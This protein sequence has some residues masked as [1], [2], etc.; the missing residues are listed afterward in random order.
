MVLVALTLVV[1]CPLP[2]QLS[3]EG[4]TTSSTVLTQQLLW[5]PRKHPA[6]LHMRS[7]DYGLCSP[8][9]LVQ[10]PPSHCWHTT[11]PAALSRSLCS[12][13]RFQSPC[14]CSF[15]PPLPPLFPLV[16]QSLSSLKSIILPTLPLKCA[17]RS[18][19]SP[20]GSQLLTRWTSSQLPCH[21]KLGN[22]Y[23]KCSDC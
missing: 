23:Q 17:S 10:Q 7:T 15:S 14:H 22:P 2:S 6:W 19:S 16:A 21:G 1:Q 18:P 12:R 3:T 4:W 8:S 11:S 9:P 13:R 5:L 20:R